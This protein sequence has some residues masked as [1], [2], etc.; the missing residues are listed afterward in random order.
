MLAEK[1]AVVYA[2]GASDENGAV[3]MAVVTM[4]ALRSIISRIE[5]GEDL[6]SQ[7]AEIQ[8]ISLG[9]V[10]FLGAPLE[11]MQAIKNDIVVAAKAPVTLVMGITN[12]SMGYAPDR[13]AAARGGYASDTVPM[14]VGRMP[15]LDIHTELVNAFLETDCILSK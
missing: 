5:K 1:E 13:T 9:P 6:Q 7:T 15:F 4:I 11:I 14:I 12:G 3:R 2:D 8:G 10:E